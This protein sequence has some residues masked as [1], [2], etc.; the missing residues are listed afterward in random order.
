[1]V[2]THDKYFCWAVPPTNME[3]TFV[4]DLEFFW[5]MFCKKI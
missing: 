1:M 2:K 3:G 5:K 4:R